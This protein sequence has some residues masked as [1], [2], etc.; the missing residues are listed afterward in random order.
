MTD[1]ELLSKL[2]KAVEACKKCRLYKNATK[3]VPGHGNPNAEIAFVGEAPGYNEDQQGL[4]FVGRA[5]KL[6]DSM[7]NSI[8]VNRES[9][10]IG[11]IIK[12]RPPENRDPMK[13]E[14]RQCSSFLEEQLKVIKPKIIVTLGRI[15]LEY[16]VKSAKI[17]EYHGKPISYKGRVFFPLYHP[18]AA[19]RNSN[20]ARILS[21]DFKKLPKVLK[22]E[23][24]AV[25]LDKK[26]QEEKDEE[27]MSF[28]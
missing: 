3:A 18:A 12:H 5:G 16:F 17:S 15:S 4:P 11:N 27:Q 14:V 9:V 10:W 28:I 26:G 23:L 8:K 19:L 24:S 20:I 2:E 25:S 1:E 22:G 6:L 21:E 13:D 7:L